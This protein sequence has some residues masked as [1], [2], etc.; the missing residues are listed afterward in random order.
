MAFD[1]P[2]EADRIDDFNLFSAFVRA[3]LWILGGVLGGNRKNQQTDD[4]DELDGALPRIVI[5]CASNENEPPSDEM[6]WKDESG[7]VT[8]ATMPS[9]EDCSSASCCALDPPSADMRRKNLSWSDESGKSLVEYNDEVSNFVISCFVFLFVL[10]KRL[11]RTNID[12]S[13]KKM[14][15]LG[16]SILNTTRPALVLVSYVAPARYHPAWLPG[17]KASS[18][19]L[20]ANNRVVVSSIFGRKGA[21]MSP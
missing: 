7:K 5:K 20:E 9:E 4:E 15:A 16:L 8:L 10:R 21:Q 17:R 2:I 6:L 12:A 18:S 3:P 14:L 1:R 19:T 13:P 11:M